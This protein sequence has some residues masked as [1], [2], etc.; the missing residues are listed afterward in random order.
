M[1]ILATAITVAAI[2]TSPLYPAATPADRAAASVKRPPIVDVVTRKGVFLEDRPVGIYKANRKAPQD[3][4]I[5]HWLEG[6]PMEH[7]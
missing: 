2:L 4:Y 7:P 1:N 6:Y 3:L 5:E